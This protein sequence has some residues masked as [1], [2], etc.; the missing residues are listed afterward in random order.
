M[1]KTPTLRPG[2]TCPKLSDLL[3]RRG[4]TLSDF[5]S[6]LD[7]SS[8]KELE[9]HCLMNLLEKDVTPLL[10]ENSKQTKI[11]LQQLAPKKEENKEITKETPVKSA[12]KEEKEQKLEKPKPAIKN[13]SLATINDLS[14][15]VKV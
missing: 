2:Q 1:Q 3:S 6:E 10:K 8:D 9:V 14:S 5:M 13:E 15:S 7:L 4:Q 12:Q 11:A